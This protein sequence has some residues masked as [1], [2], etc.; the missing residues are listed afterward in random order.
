MS[1]LS[2]HIESFIKTLLEEDGAAD[3]RRNELAVKFN[4]APSQINYVLTTRFSPGRGYVIQSRRGG[5]GFVRVIRLD[6]DRAGYIIDIIE[7]E[8]TGE[9]NTRRAALIVGDM[10]CNGFIN[11]RER[12]MLHAAV[13]DKALAHVGEERDRV[14]A[15]VLRE[16][17][18]RII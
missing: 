3:L 12:D 17:L 7:S 5:G 1:V 8:L 11:K 4:C 6:L 14:R 9:I 13:S 2:D 15:S 16:M 10:Y 18:V